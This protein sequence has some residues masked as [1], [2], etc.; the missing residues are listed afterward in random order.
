MLGKNND[1]KGHDTRDLHYFLL[2]YN[3]YSVLKILGKIIST[4]YL[5]TI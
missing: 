5:I 2:L 3:K 4:Y 1:R